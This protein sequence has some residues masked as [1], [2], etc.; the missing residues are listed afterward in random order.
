[1][2]DREGKVLRRTEQKDIIGLTEFKGQLL[3]LKNDGGVTTE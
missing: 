3:L 2:S 1:V